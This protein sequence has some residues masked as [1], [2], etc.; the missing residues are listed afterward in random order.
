MQLQE[1]DQTVPDFLNFQ[2]KIFRNKSSM[3][4]SGSCSYPSPG[5]FDCGQKTVF[6]I[7]TFLTTVM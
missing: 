2:F 4:K 6:N 5:V 7:V 3:D 1:M